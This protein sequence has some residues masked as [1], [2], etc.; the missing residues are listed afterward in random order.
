MPKKRKYENEWKI[1]KEK[2]TL[3]IELDSGVLPPPKQVEAY[4]KT[5]VRMVSKEKYNDWHFKHKYPNSLIE[6]EV[7]SAEAGILKLVLV[8]DSKDVSGLF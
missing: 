6:V 8:Y 1:L 5:F 7:R 2:G 3:T 4:F